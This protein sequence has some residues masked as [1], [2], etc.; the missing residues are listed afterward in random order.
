M[1]N[2]HPA[3][4]GDD[5]DAHGHGDRVP[6]AEPGGIPADLLPYLDAADEP[7]DAPDSDAPDDG[8]DPEAER[9]AALRALVEHSLLVGPDPSILAEIDGDA[10]DD[11]DEDDATT[12]EEPTGPSA[13]D[14]ALDAAQAAVALDARV[15]EIYQSIIDRAPEHRVQ[16]S[17]DRVRTALD[18]LGDPHTAYPAIHITGT[19]GKTSTARMAD[20]LLTAFGMR[21]GRFTSPHLLDVRER[22]SLEGEPISR[23]GF[24]AAWED[25]APYIS[26]ADD[27]STADG[28]P[29]LSFFEVFTVMA[30]AAF[31][32]YPVDAAVVEV[33]MGGQWDATNVL[34]AGVGVI[35]PIGLDH[36]AWLG[37]TIAD[38]A[39]E[40]A[41]IIAPGQITVIAEQ[42][43]E[44]LDVLL[45]RARRC[46]AIVRLEGRDYEVLDRQIGVGGQLVSIRTP[47]AVYEDVFIPLFGEHQA[48]NAA[49][50]LVAVEA[51]MGGRALDPR[52]VEQ[53]MMTAT[54]PGRLHVV[55]TS[56]TILV[57]AAHNPAGARTLRGALD[58]SFGFAH[59]VGV[60]SAMGDKDAEG[61]LAE[62]EPFL[63]HLVVTQMPGERAA[64]V[65]DLRAVAEDVFGPDRVDVREGLA[66]AVDRAA[67]LAEA[68]TDPSDRSGVVVFGSVA[69]AGQMLALAGKRP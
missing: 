54:S 57:D 40:K 1:A 20:A 63:D 10:D 4:F 7:D 23:E 6:P 3:F 12:G 31:A 34:D 55:R 35:T 69:L 33:G 26:M 21:V 28:G 51:F 17:L 15:D 52:I 13:H 19:N 43:D 56:P 29:R 53:A 22:I 8:P 11:W 41:G 16:P 48:R 32:D 38:I 46:D 25:V 37:P 49:A 42:P 59:A 2:E 61:V 58:E 64:D 14:R 24:I 65:D 68:S 9:A 66:D 27:A 5:E 18:I 47:A 30:Y 39:R 62:V 45:E 44:A 36:T 60:Y 50:A 67:E